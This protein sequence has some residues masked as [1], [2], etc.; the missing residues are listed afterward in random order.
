MWSPTVEAWM[1][2]VCSVIPGAAERSTSTTESASKSITT[3]TSAPCT[4]SEGL[5]ATVAPSSASGAARSRVRFQTV[6][7]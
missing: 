3:T 6:T 5:S 7:G 1:T 2:T 4:A